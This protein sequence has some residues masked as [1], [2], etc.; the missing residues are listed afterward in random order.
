MRIRQG[1]A[2]GRYAA[3]DRA[4]ERCLAGRL[5]TMRGQARYALR[6]PKR[7]GLLTVTSGR[8]AGV[9]IP[10]VADVVEMYAAR[11]A[12]GAIMVRAA[13]R[14]TPAGRSL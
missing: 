4:T 1:V 8:P 2:D 11:R 13:S 5:H 7:D 3:R 12:L 14:W 6:L 9:P 10:T